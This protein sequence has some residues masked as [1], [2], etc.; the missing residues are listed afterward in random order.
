M[1]YAFLIKHLFISQIYNYN[2]IFYLIY[3]DKRAIGRNKN[4][5][6]STILIGTYVLSTFNLYIYKE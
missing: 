4:V 2:V 3:I 5:N 6:N 1:R